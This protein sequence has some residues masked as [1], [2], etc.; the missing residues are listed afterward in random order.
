[1][2]RLFNILALIGVFP[3]A[4]RAAERPN[5]V[6]I[7]ADDL[8]YADIGSF[9]AKDFETPKLDRMA[10]EGRRFTDFYVGGPACTPSRAALMTGCYPVRAGFADQIAYR[11]DGT[12][13][14][15]RVLWPNSK[16]GLNAAEVTVPEVLRDAGYVTGMV[17]KWHLGD[18]PKFN[19]VHH[20]FV[21][22]FGA[23]YSHDMKPYYFL[24]GETK[25]PGTPDLDHHVGRYTEE[26]TKF[27]RK[28]AATNKPFFLYFAHHNPHTPLVASENFKGKTKRGAYGD[29]VAELDWSVGKV[30]DELR[31][32]NLDKRTLVIFTSDNGPWLVRGEQGGS[33]TPF[34]GGKGTTYEGGMREPCVMWW[35]GT[36]RAGTTCHE[37]AATLDFLPTFAVLAGVKPP[38]DRTIDGHDIRPLLNDDEAKTPWK[39]FYFYLG[40]ELHAV[41]SGEWKLRS[42][43][44]FFNENIYRKDAPKELEIPEALYNLRLDPG[45]QKSV[46]KDHP[47]IAKRLE[48][49]LEDARADL[50]DSL[51]GVAPKHARPPGQVD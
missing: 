36:I 48:S 38:S 7:L 15:S 24:R 2:G 44:N 22:F 21:E 42:K 30:L 32:L 39:A 28:A 18:A 47:Q 25:V 20:G 11:A 29:A 1:M 31:T 27:I 35:P 33:A 50:G 41:R 46:L 10:N 45:E 8:G 3:I 49:Y 13:S 4:M 16:W 37:I 26:A 9:G 17:G 12:F 5:I 40:N 43:N 23:P 6:L 19:P 14:Q 51:T 34:R